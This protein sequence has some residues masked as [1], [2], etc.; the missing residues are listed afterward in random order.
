MSGDL[1]SKCGTSPEAPRGVDAGALAD[2]PPGSTMRAPFGD[3]ELTLANIDGRVVAVVDLCLRCSSPLSSGALRDST[4]I[5]LHC[6]WQYDLE[7]G[8]V[9]GL[10]ALKLERHAVRVENGRVLVM[11]EAAAPVGTT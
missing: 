8:E 5:C 7:R 3:A 10:P 9:V 4:L 6:G 11:N 1:D 2:L